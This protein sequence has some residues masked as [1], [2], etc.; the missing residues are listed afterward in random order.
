MIA[1]LFQRDDRVVLKVS[2]TFW[3]VK[4]VVINGLSITS[5]YL[6][7]KYVTVDIT[8]LQVCHCVVTTPLGRYV[9]LF[10]SRL[11]EIPK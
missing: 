7:L 4:T 11:V 2:N 1:S 10:Q 8:V 6:Q 5:I 9:L 3:L